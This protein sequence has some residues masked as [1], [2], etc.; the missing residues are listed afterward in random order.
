M[1]PLSLP[2]HGCEASSRASAT[3]LVIFPATPPPFGSG[4]LIGTLGG[5]IGLG[6]AE[7][8]LPLL[9]SLVHFRGLEA[10]ILNKATSL[11][12]VATAL[13]FRANSVSFAEII[14]NLLG[15]S[16][17]GAWAGAEWATKKR[18]IE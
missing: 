11:V 4:A 15:G 2:R 8:R 12:V 1:R 7:F 14:L 6:G 3:N 13:P 16:P 9:I 10:V 17:I 18:S 5:V